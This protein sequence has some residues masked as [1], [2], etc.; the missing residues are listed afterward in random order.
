MAFFAGYNDELTHLMRVDRDQPG[1]GHPSRLARQRRPGPARPCRGRLPRSHLANR[2]AEGQIVPEMSTRGSSSRND[3]PSEDLGGM[4]HDRFTS[5][6]GYTM[7]LQGVVPGVGFMAFPPPET[8]S[9]TRIE[10]RRRIP[11]KPG[12]R[13]ISVTIEHPAETI[14]HVERCVAKKRRRRA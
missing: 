6:G 1:P 14:R 11:V 13:A 2:Y 12:G 8:T 10:E 7:S 3:L 9:G 5:I 4:S